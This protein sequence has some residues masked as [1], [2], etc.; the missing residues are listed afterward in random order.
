MRV[1]WGDG[2]V[3]GFRGGR[4]ARGLGGSA[5]GLGGRG[6]WVEEGEGIRSAGVG[7]GRKR[8]R[9]SGCFLERGVRV[10]LLI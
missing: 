3:V 10:A 2:G 4:G 9:W 5:R 1:G 8:D 7:E 6:D